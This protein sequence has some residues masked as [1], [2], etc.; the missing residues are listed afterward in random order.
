MGKIIEVGDR[1]GNVVV[2]E[3]SGYF[4]EPSGKKRKLWTCRCD[5]GNV[6]EIRSRNLRDSSACSECIKERMR[7]RFSKMKRKLETIHRSRYDH[8]IARCYDENEI[9]Y[10]NYGARGIS[11]CE[12]WLGE[13]GLT[14]FCKDM[15]ECP[16]GYT[17]DRIDVNGN[18]SPENCR[19]APRSVQGFNTRKHKTNTSGRTGV[20]WFKRVNKWIAAIVY[21]GVQIHLGYFVNFD[22]AVKARE[23]AEIKYFGE[24]RPEAKNND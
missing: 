5:C 8:M 15:G 1:F 20:Y 7:V 3:L 18:Y 11:V 24:L 17:L 23:D 12:A 10:E 16:D 13:N 6:V 22:D 2:L 9:G 21:N 4:T 14:N 19:W